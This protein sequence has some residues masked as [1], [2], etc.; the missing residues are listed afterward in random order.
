MFCF[1]S[2]VF[3]GLRALPVVVQTSPKN[4]VAVYMVFVMKYVD[5]GFFMRSLFLS[6]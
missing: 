5:T 1:S 2:V 6:L 3:V 4:G